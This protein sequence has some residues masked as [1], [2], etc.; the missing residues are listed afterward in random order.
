MGS[1]A[2]LMNYARLTDIH[3]HCLQPKSLWRLSVMS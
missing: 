2:N 3:D 1:T